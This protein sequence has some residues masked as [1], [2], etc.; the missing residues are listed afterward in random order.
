MWR[1]SHKSLL[2]SPFP[3]LWGALWVYLG[4][5]CYHTY[6]APLLGAALSFLGTWIYLP[7][8]GPVLF[9]TLF[10]YV[11]KLQKFG[12]PSVTTPYLVAEL[13]GRVVGCVCVRMKHTCYREA[14]KGV[15]EPAGEASVWRLS[16]HTSA[17]KHGVGR[18]LMAAA[19]A[20]AV[21]HRAKYM[22]LITG[23]EQSRK[24]YQRLGYTDEAE[25]RARRVLFGPTLQPSTIVGSLRALSLK[26]RLA[27][28]IMSKELGT[29]SSGGKGVD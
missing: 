3:L 21:E 9:S 20:F 19:E 12:S 29:G 15:E 1:T 5:H 24:F 28:T 18:A 26:G 22:S 13:D 25:G 10:F 27:T 6:Q 7:F 14:S 23:N 11:I 16:V 2:T 17:R 4:W 8:I